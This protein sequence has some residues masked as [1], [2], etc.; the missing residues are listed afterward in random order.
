MDGVFLYPTARMVKGWGVH[1][2]SARARLWAVGCGL[3]AVGCGLWAVGCGL[4]AVGCGLW[5]A[6]CGLWAAR[7]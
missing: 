3:W 1:S 4:W 5:A 2:A 6:G 7:A